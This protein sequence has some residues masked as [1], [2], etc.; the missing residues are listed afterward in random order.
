MEFKSLVDQLCR[1]CEE[2][3]I[4]PEANEFPN[5]DE[6]NQGKFCEPQF[7]A[8]RCWN[9]SVQA[10]GPHECIHRDREIFIRKTLQEIFKKDTIYE[11]KVSRL[12]SDIKEATKSAPADCLF[13]FE[14]PQNYGQRRH[15]AIRYC[16][17][18]NLDLK[19]KC[20]S[21]R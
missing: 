14:E 15:W 8:L 1:A 3:L 10:D 4:I 7:Q 12:K 16:E 2:Y 17:C 18:G 20:F 11:M 5:Q 13:Y 21:H 6:L 19:Q 9:G